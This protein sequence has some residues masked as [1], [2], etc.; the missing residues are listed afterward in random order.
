M[1]SFDGYLTSIDLSFLKNDDNFAHDGMYQDNQSDLSDP[2]LFH[3]DA[4]LLDIVDGN[5]NSDTPFDEVHENVKA[6]SLDEVPFD[7]DI[8]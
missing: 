8:R 4:H 7:R 5:T 2:D 6:L 3:D 1:T